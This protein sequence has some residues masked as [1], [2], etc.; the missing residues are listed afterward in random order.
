V[1]DAPTET[2]TKRAREREKERK[3][4]R[5]KQREHQETRHNILLRKWGERNDC[6]TKNIHF[7]FYFNYSS[8]KNRWVDEGGK[9][10]LVGAPDADIVLKAIEELRKR[11]TALAATRCFHGMARQDKSSSLHLAR[12]SPEK[13]HCEL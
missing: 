2:V 13:K 12:V 3:R 4:K 8:N 10:T 6:V 1:V 11:T 7:H 5:T 9:A